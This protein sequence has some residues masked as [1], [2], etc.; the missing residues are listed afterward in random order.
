VPRGGV[1]GTLL[2]FLLTFMD[3]VLLRAPQRKYT[4]VAKVPHGTSGTNSP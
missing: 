4:G 2:A 1:S 3:D